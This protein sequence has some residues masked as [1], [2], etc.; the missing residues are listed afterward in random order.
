MK[1]LLPMI[2]MLVASLPAFA[3]EVK[4]MCSG[5]TVEGYKEQEVV[6]F[7]AS[8]NTVEGHVAKDVHSLSTYRYVLNEQWIG[9]G[10]D[11]NIRDIIWINR[12]NATCR[13]R[14]DGTETTSCKCEPFKQAF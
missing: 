11:E 3:D 6:R 9:L 4:L 10:L 1:K 5:T 14:K 8:N 12:L 7:D 2:L 13:I